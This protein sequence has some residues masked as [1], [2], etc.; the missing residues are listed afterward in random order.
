MTT[1]NRLTRVAYLEDGDIVP[2]FDASDSRTRAVSI[3]VIRQY[4]AE[5]ITHD[6][7]IQSA[8]IEGG[9]LI[10][11]TDDGKEIDA[12]PF[13]EAE[14]LTPEEIKQ[15]LE[16]LPDA[17]KLSTDDLKDVLISLLRKTKKIR[18]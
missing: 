3:G 12:G 6:V 8:K 11:I 13:P 16:S 4:L 15:K 18:C 14:Q 17:D 9:H 2:I 10:F 1:I 7:G 5:T